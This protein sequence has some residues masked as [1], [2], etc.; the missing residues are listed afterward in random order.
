[1]ILGER[2]EEYA[3]RGRA[4]VRTSRRLS[5]PIDLSSKIALVTGASQGIGAEIARTF[6]RAGAEVILNHPGFGSTG[7]DAAKIA[8][9]LNSARDGS[10]RV[11]EANVADADAV[12]RM[13]RENGPIDFLINNAAI[14]RDRTV[15]KMSDEE[16]QSVIDVNLSGVFHC[17]KHGLEVM[18]D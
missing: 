10:A 16:W 14:I 2:R 3:C 18:R 15:A 1:E 5:L 13:M 6:H 9:E 8:A 11:A 12:Q 17:C 4:A 7:A